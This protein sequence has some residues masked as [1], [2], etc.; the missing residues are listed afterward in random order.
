MAQKDKSEFFDIKSLLLSYRTHW[1]WFAISVILCLTIAFVYVRTHNARYLVRANVIVSDDNTGSFTA[2]SGIGDLFG[3]RANV[4]DEVYVIS[5]HTVLRDVARD[6]GV[7]KEHIVKD[8]FLK[9]SLHYP[10]YPLDIYAAPG[11]LDTLRTSLSFKVSTD[12]K[13]I[14]D[15]KIFC[16]GKKIASYD[17]CTLPAVLKTMYGDFTLKATDTYPKGKKVKST[18]TVSGYDIAAEGLAEVVSSSKASRKSNMVE[19][20]I[21]TDNPAYG[22]AVLD[23]IMDN[24]NR[25]TVAYQNAQGEKTQ[26]FINERLALISGDLADA[27]KDIQ[28]YK[29]QRGITDVAAEA[30]YNMK[31]R[32]TAD[33]AL[34][35]AETQ[36]ELIR[37]TRDFLRKPENAYELIPVTGE[38]GSVSSSIKNYNDLVIWRMQLTKNA[39]KDNAALRQ[40]DEQ[41]NSL[42]AVINESLEKAY[43]ASLVSIREARQ[44]LNASMT[45]LGNVP[46]QEREFLGLKRQQAVKQ[47]LYIFLLQRREETAMMIAN[48]LPKG[49]IVD[50]AYT[51]SEPVSMKKRIILAI[52]L[53]LGIII[54]M[55][56]LYLRSL[57][58]TKVDTSDDLR[59]L[60][61][62]PV[63]GE[64]CNDNTGQSLVV[65]TDNTS[66]TAELFRMV[67]SNLQFMCN[68]PSNVIIVTSTRSGEGK[69]F[70]SVN[71]AAS[72]ALAGKKVV[73]V[74]MDI[75]KPRLGEYLNISHPT[76]VT[77]YLANPT[78]SLGSLIIKSPRTPGC[79]VIL[80]G[81]V[82]PN[83]NELLTSPATVHF[84]EKLRGMYD[85]II[86]DSAPVGMVSDTLALASMADM[87]IYVTRANFTTHRDIEFVNDLAKDK[88]LPRVSLVL[89]GVVL[90]SKTGYGYGYG[91]DSSK[92]SK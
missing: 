16:Q 23:E 55:I 31:V 36:S 14:A 71:L 58:R 32:G 78:D 38:I 22:T 40:L 44:R 57:F 72:L 77:N 45:R 50:Q 21:V 10:D 68:K 81:P 17:D 86:V 52:A 69:S 3:S 53:F 67:R 20:S 80:A 76:G 27:E 13:G 37:M 33:N 7:Y 30:E 54:P 26:K 65:E 87:T 46:A 85:Y 89:N 83:P 4:E 51:L 12:K 88:R 64:I 42:R 59:K 34:V 48:A 47:E 73:L 56:L 92:K 62:V 61:D 90:R 63:L 9:K 49:R 70:I 2:M 91:H 29:N 5:S 18:I 25:R 79:D 66:S 41:I 74:G 84:F 28:S 6:L 43:Q 35:A 19:M 15:V 75:R 1:W 8:G 82:P 39:K 24:Y 60:S 11:L